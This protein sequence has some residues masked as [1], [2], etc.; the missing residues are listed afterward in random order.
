[1]TNLSFTINNTVFHLVP[2]EERFEWHTSD[3]QCR[4]GSNLTGRLN[5]YWARCGDLLVGREY[6][7]LGRAMRAASHFSELMGVRRATPHYAEFD[8][9]WEAA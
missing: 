8:Q 1:M 5:S 6:R 9:E 7:T 4:I 3:G 2:V